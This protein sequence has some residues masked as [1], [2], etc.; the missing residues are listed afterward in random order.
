MESMSQQFG[1]FLDFS[2]KSKSNVLNYLQNQDNIDPDFANYED[3]LVRKEMLRK[4]SEKLESDPEFREEY[5]RDKK[6]N[7]EEVESL[8][9]KI[10]SYQP[11]ET[12]QISKIPDS[13][14]KIEKVKKNK[15]KNI[16]NKNSIIRIDRVNN[17]NININISD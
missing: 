8:S 2:H 3:I 1:D 17:L 14:E 13:P 5:I 6:A 9:K 11:I 4:L 16:K 7:M 15:K 12:D 10:S